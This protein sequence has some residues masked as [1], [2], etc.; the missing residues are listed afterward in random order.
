[1]CTVYCVVTSQCLTSSLNA[2]RKLS[3]LG[4][5]GEDFVGLKIIKYRNIH[6]IAGKIKSTKFSQNV[7][8]FCQGGHQGFVLEVKR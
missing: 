6:Y 3:K 2:V 1:M 4:K 8:I 5:L 7:V